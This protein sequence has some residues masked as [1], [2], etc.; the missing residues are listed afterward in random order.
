MCPIQ[1]GLSSLDLLCCF[2]LCLFSCVLFVFFLEVSHI[3][4]LSRQGRQ[5]ARYI[6]CW[7]VL[8]QRPGRRV[9][10]CNCFSL[11]I[12]NI[13]SFLITLILNAAY[14]LK[15]Q[16]SLPCAESATESE[17]VTELSLYFPPNR[18][19]WWPNCNLLKAHSGLIMLKMPLKSLFHSLSGYHFLAL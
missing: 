15:A 7:R 3:I 2:S 4:V 11:H 5:I 18:C 8:L 10:N 12:L 17:S 1:A 19:H 14:L 13:F 16:Y 9:I 6:S